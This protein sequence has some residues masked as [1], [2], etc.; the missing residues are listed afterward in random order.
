MPLTPLPEHAN[1]LTH[2]QALIK[3]RFDRLAELEVDRDKIKSEE[4][5]LKADIKTLQGAG[6]KLLRIISPIRKKT[7]NTNV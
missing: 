3:E 4:N 7:D 5:K 1:D 2:I 6:K